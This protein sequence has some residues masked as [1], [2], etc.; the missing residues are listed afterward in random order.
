MVS[1]ERYYDYMARRLKEEEDKLISRTEYERAV[2]EL[3]DMYYKLIIRNK[4]LIEEN[5]KLRNEN[6]D[7]HNKE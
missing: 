6:A 7:L 1:D 4:E 5:E 2:K 3:N